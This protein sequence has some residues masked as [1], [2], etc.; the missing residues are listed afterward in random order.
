MGVNFS[1]H[2]RRKNEVVFWSPVP[3][4]FSMNRVSLAG[5]L[6]GLQTG[7]ARRDL[8][9][10]PYIGSSS[11]RA[12]GTTARPRPGFRNSADVGVDLK[13]AITPGLT[14]DVTIHPDFGQ[15]EADAQ[16]VNLTQ[17]SQFFPRSATSSSRTRA[18]STSA[19]PPATIA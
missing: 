11:V 2:I 5:N 1:R 7:S 9:I 16:Q 10:K 12:L 4:A 13:A 19:M 14:V 15:V 6:A 8:R 3:R 18:S 17:F